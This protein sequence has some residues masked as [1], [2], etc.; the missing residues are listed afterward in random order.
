MGYYVRALKDKKKRPHWKIQFISSRRKDQRASSQAKSPKRTWDL[1]KDRWRPLGFHSSMTIEE[2]RVRAKQLNSQI[3]LKQQEE[4]I[5]KFKE[6][7]Y[8]FILRNDSVLPEEFVAEFEIRFVHAS[9]L[10]TPEQ[11][12]TRSQQRQKLWRSARRMIVAVGQEPVE[13]IYHSE[14]FYEHL[15]VNQYSI[16]YSLALISMANLWGQFITR[17]LAQPF[18]PVRIPRGYERQRILEA[19]YH[20]KSKHR[21]PSKPITPG[22]LELMKARMKPRGFN[23][24][25]ISVW[26]GLRPKEIDLLHDKQMWKLEL[27]A[28][29]LKVLWIYQTKIIA[30]PREERWKPIPILF[31]EQHFALK[32]I[33]D[34]NFKRPIVRSIHKYL[35][36][37]HDL[38]GGRKGFVDLMLSRNQSFENI[39]VWMGHSTLNRTWRTY[40]SRRSFHP[41]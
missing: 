19:F 35:G 11:R 8:Q 36:E 37:G 7:E 16:G 21:K 23:W 15:Y 41:S 27:T 6:K 20:K 13:W 38:Y 17:K 14:K 24:L 1:T 29:G 4:R 31:D 34:Q 5:R 40:K 22:H 26:F 2:A 10:L 32:I 25:F 3:R 28:N 18:C 9:R 39:S 33:S 12:K 30:L